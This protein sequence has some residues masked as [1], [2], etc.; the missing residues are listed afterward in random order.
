MGSPNKT[1]IHMQQKF[2]TAGINSLVHPPIFLSNI[3]T[4]FLKNTRFKNLA[5]KMPIISFLKASSLYIFL[6]YFASPGL[7]SLYTLKKFII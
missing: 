6:T 5:L 4:C 1:S 3:Y 7:K 2:P